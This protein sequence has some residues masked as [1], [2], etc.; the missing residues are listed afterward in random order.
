MPRRDI[1]KP[2]EC[3]TLYGLFRERLRRSPESCAYRDFERTTKQWVD[4][5]WGEFAREVARWQTALKEE[6][7]VPGDRVAL[8]LRNSR[9]WAIFEQAALGLGLVVVSLYT[10]DRPDNA[11]YSIQDS[12]AALLLVQDAAHWRRFGAALARFDALKVVLIG[13]PDPHLTDSRVRWTSQWLPQEPGELVEDSV[14]PGDLATIAYTSGTGGNPKGV[15]LSHGNI[16]SVAYAGLQVVSI[17]PCD[18]FLSFL[19]LSHMFERTAGYYLPMMAGATVAHARSVAQLGEDLAT[20]RPTLMLAVPRIFERLH[21]R[22]QHTLAKSAGYKRRLFMKTVDVGWSR[23]LYK[24]GKGRWSFRLLL[25]PVLNRMVAQPVLQ[26]FG[27]RLRVVVS[28]GAPIGEDIAKTFLGLGLPILQGYGLTETGPQ[29]SVNPPEDNDPRSVGVVLPGTQVRLGEGDEL[30]VFGPGVMMGYWNNPE[31]T[32]HVFTGDG[33]LRTGDR[34][35]IERDHIYIVGRLK[36]ILVLSNGEKVPP[37]DMETAIASDPLFE[38]VMVFGEGRPFLAAI[39]VFNED[40]WPTFARSLDLSADRE[41]LL[42]KAVNRAVLQRISDLLRRFPTYAKIRRVHV[43]LEHW[44]VD[45]GLMT[46]TLKVKRQ[47]VLDYYDKE[48]RVMYELDAA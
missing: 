5:S 44:S 12:G 8:S 26:K 42:H 9:E 34:A 32:E 46:P 43:T 31:A 13:E 40:A 41:N 39:V 47:Q 21:A 45:N 35:A 24:Q 18:V 22:M 11:A 1:I 16:L 7:L 6:G 2:D 20:I 29:V 48:I 33:W 14:D 3:R 23:F 15:M 19:P 4:M 25:W 30:E 38:Q 10:D 27:G 17:H 37:G 28:G 36:D